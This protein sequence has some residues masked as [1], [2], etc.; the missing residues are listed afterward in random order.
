MLAERKI[1]TGSKDSALKLMNFVG[2]RR[3]RVNIKPKST[4][5]QLRSRFI[6]C[7]EGLE[8]IKNFMM[9]GKSKWDIEF[10]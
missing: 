10:L 3:V 2:C 1:G 8:E 6:V 7:W 4:Q 5:K 9:T